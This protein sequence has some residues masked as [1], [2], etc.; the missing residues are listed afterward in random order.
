MTGRVLLVEDE[1]VVAMLLEDCL[2]ELGY[3]IA[4]TVGDVDAGLEEVKKGI[5]IWRCWTSILAAAI[6][7]RSPRNW[8][9]AECRIF[10]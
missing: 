4:A 5:L 7:F 10:L 2:I 3:E 1:S 8:M 6:P 9:P